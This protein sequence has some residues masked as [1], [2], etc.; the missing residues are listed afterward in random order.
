MEPNSKL[1]KTT[2]LID[3]IEIVKEDV[4][5]A[6]EGRLKGPWAEKIRQKYKTL[7]E[8]IEGEV[9]LWMSRFLDLT[10]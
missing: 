6:W 5:K 2:S 9:K 8:A 7:E 1:R 10:E 4:K 3:P